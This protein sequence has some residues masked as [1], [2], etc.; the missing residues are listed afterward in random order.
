MLDLYTKSASH[1]LIV[2]NILK[3]SLNFK[4]ETHMVDKY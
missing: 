1:S 4:N 3:Y 2:P